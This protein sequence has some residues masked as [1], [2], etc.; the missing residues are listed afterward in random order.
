[1]G[2]NWEVPG[3]NAGRIKL[4]QLE[5]RV[6]SVKS[7]MHHAAV[8]IGIVNDPCKISTFANLIHHYAHTELIPPEAKRTI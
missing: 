8:G 3:L 2:G 4:E 6:T 7:E 1:L 5:T